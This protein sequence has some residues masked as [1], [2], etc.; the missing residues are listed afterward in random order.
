MAIHF[1]DRRTRRDVLKLGVAGAAGLCAGGLGL[2]KAQDAAPAAAKKDI[3]VALQLYSVRGECDK[4]KG[5]NL[6]PVVPTG[7]A[8]TGSCCRRCASTR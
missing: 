6:K 4:D 7:R 8:V 2:L 1:Q 3:P 5:K